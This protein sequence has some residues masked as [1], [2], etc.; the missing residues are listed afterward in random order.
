MIDLDPATTAF[1]IVDMQNDFC[2]ADG[3]YARAGRN[4]SQLAAAT[5]PVARLLERARAVG[6]T[7]AFTRL[8]H[9]EARGAMEERHTIKPRLW[10]AHGKRLTPGTWGADVLDALRPAPGELIIDKY[11]FS[12]FD[13][14]TLE[15]DLH[16]RGI[17]TLLLAGVV[18]Y[19]CVLATGFAAFDRGFDVLLV[20][21]AV[22]SWND[23]LGASTSEM[24][25]LLLGRAVT[26]DELNLSSKK[27]SVTE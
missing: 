3:Y 17:K 1:V 14:T 23:K 11:G 27:T 2:H 21:D 24:V 20:K 8:V 16:E 4:I 25:D 10:T 5:A 13:D 9:D 18:T 22:G 6:L 15:K 7:V 26:S 12:A 19:A